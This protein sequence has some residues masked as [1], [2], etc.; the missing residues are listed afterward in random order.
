MGGDDSRLASSY[1]RAQLRCG[2]GAISNPV[3]TARS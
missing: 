1:V 2:L 3:T